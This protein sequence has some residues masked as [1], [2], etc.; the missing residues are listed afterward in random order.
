MIDILI[1][2]DSPSV[3]HHLKNILEAE[4]DMHVMGIASNGAEAVRLSKE[5]RPDVI[6]MDINM[7]EMNGLEATRLIM[8]NDPVP[9]VIVSASFDP[10]DVE[11]SF[12]AMEAGA[13]GIAE[14]PFGVGHPGYQ[15]AARNLVRTVRAM[16]EVKVVKRWPRARYPAAPRG[17][18]RL[19]KAPQK[20]SM[21]AIGASTGGPP[22]LQ[23]I[24]SGLTKGFPAP[25]LVVQHISKGFLEGLVEWL[26]NTTRHPVHIASE[27]ERA[28]PGHVYFAPEDLHMGI[29]GSGRIALNASSPENGIRPS[30]SYLFRS[31]LSSYGSEAVGVLLT[32]MGRDGADELK[33]LKDKGAVTIV[34]DKESSVVHGMPGEALKLEAASYVLAPEKITAAL[35]TL[36]SRRER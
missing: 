35:E 5:K 17:E 12:L 25:I 20:V 19:E 6:T 34:Q 4:A 28:L 29:T 27:G 14:K 9:I 32:G 2:E 23:T 36:F 33:M 7:P 30:V 3:Q 18:I 13:V 26:G 22:V 24:L 16:A 11:K 31:A 1:V 15:E 10:R 8:E 21:V